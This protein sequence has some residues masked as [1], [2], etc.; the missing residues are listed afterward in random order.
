MPEC[1]KC[2][3]PATRNI[4]NI[5]VEYSIDKKGNYSKEPIDEWEGDSNDHLCDDCE[6]D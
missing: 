1:D 4:Q 6:L 5:W 2:G 3:K